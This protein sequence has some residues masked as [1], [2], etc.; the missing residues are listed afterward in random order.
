MQ[1]TGQ[2][3]FPINFIEQS[4]AGGEKKTSQKE[5]KTNTKTKGSHVPVSWVLFTF[6]QGFGF[7]IFNFQL[8]EEGVVL[9]GAF[10]ALDRDGGWELGT[11]I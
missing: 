7:V 6:C 5:N 8:R 1:L 3:I 11:L 10:S 9:A 2:P 4:L